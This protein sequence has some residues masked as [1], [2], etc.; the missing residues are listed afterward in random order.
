MY[1]AQRKTVIL[2]CKFLFQIQILFVLSMLL[3]VH[4]SV[5]FK[6][7]YYFFI[8]LFLLIKNP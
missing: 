4:R 5:V 8:Y 6:F 7:F 2:V 3:F 1:G